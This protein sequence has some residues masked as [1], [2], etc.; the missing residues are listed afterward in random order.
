MLKK[1][2]KY[3]DYDGEQREK[4]YFFNLNKSEIIELEMSEDGGLENTINKIVQ[5]REGGK[6]MALF[7][8]IILMSVGD[9]T[10]ADRFVKNEEIRN[11]FEQ[12]PAYDALF[13]ELISD[14]EAA[15]KFIKGIMPKDL[16][17]DE[18]IA[19]AKLKALPSGN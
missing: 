11:A 8:K 16:N 6:I 9:K 12:S 1:T 4:D 2:I 14:T 15:A 10:T 3:E 5:S 7:K 18:A 13:M 17:T 19:Q